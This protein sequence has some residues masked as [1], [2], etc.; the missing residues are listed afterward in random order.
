MLPKPV[1]EEYSGFLVVR[2]DLLSG[3]QRPIT[4][5]LLGDNAIKFFMLG[6]F[7]GYIIKA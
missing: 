6:D 5:E 1:I 4:R 7:V 3:V 2:D